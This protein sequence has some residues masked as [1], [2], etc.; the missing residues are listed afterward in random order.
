MQT[1]PFAVRLFVFS[2]VACSNILPMFQVKALDLE[3]LKALNEAA[4]ARA[5]ANTLA[6][7]KS[8]LAWQSKARC[9][10]LTG[11][12]TEFNLKR[13]GG[14]LGAILELTMPA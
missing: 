12:L 13:G 9:G 8:K 5:E 1:Q 7:S 3:R 2:A 14:C 6:K 10:S 4:V 11:H